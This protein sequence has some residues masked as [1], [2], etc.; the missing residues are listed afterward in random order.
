MMIS[1]YIWISSMVFKFLWDFEGCIYIYILNHYILPLK[2]QQPKKEDLEK[3][4][5]HWIIH[6]TMKSLLEMYQ[7]TEK[8]G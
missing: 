7:N 6:E 4:P 1:K 3:S 5:K 2:K 8:I